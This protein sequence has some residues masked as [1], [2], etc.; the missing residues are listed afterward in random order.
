MANN[1]KALSVREI[2]RELGVSH[3]LLVL[4]RQGKRS[5]APELEQQYHQLVTKGSVTKSVTAIGQAPRGILNRPQ[6]HGGPLA[7]LEEHRTF[8]PGAEG[9]TPSRPTISNHSGR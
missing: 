4:W 8:N 1:Q 2:G 9:S 7:Q 5:L 6:I 3:T